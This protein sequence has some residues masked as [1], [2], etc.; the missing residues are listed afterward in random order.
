MNLSPALPGAEAILPRSQSY[1]RIIRLSQY[2]T[3]HDTR[4]MNTAVPVGGL[5]AARKPGLASH[6][7]RTFITSAASRSRMDSGAT[8]TRS[9]ADDMTSYR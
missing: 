9:I 3:G 8:K 4:Y 2:E 1:R 6:F 5:T 7:H